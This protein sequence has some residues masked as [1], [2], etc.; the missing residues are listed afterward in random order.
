MEFG[1]LGPLEVRSQGR[2]VALPGVKQRALLAILLLNANEVVA[3]DRLIDALSPESGINALQALVSRLRKALAEGGQ[4]LETKPAGYLL[5]LEPGQRDLDSFEQLTAEAAMADPETAAVK[6]REALALWRGPALAEFAYADFAQS[7][8]GRLEEMRLTALERRI[9]ADLQVGRHADVVGELEQLTTQH[10]LRERLRGQL[11]LA[12]YRCGRQ[13][14]ALE[15]YQA[16]RRSL[17]E[18]LGIDPGSALRELEQAILRQDPDLE[19][20]APTGKRHPAG[21][22][23]PTNL[24]TPATPLVGRERELEALTELIGRDE[25]RLVTLTGPGGVG[26]TRLALELARSL[27]PDYPDGVY[28]L[29]LASLREPA[30]LLSTLAQAL[31]VR[32]QPKRTVLETLTDE[33]KERQLLLFLDNLEHLLEVAPDLA[34]L[35]A[36]CPKLLLLVT[37][38]QPL[39]LAGEH[40]YALAPLR[41]EEAFALFL[42]RAR[43]LEPDFS[44][45]GEVT[46]ICRR[47]DCLPLAL[48]LAAARVKAL[49]AS[50]ILERLGERLPLLTGGPRDLPE[51]QQTLRAT[52]A[53]SYDLLEEDEQRLF[54]R[55]SVFAGGCTLEA[56]EEVCETELNTLASLLDKSLLRRRGERYSMLETIREYAAERLKQA[57]EGEETKARHADYVLVLTREA[58]EELRGAEQQLWLDRLEEEQDNIRVALGWLEQTGQTEAQLDL[59]RTMSYFWDMRGRWLEGLRWLEPAL[60]RSEGER[61]ARRAQALYAAASLLW[62]Y[63][64]LPGAQAYAEESLSVS[65][66][67]GDSVEIA[68]ALIVLAIIAKRRGNFRQAERLHEAAAAHARKAGDRRLLGYTTGN[69]ATL[70]LRE[71]DYGRA[72]SLSKET[73]ALYR[74]LGAPD[75][76]GWSLLNLALSLLLA[77]GEEQ[78][79]PPARES[80]ALL[81]RVGDLR[82][83]LYTFIVFASL[84]TRRGE[85]GA[86]ARLLGAVEA[87]RERLSLAL[88]G[89]EEEL[90]ERT[91][92][93]LR[94]VLGDDVFEAH[95]AEGRSLSLDEAVAYALEVVPET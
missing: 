43:A 90:R 95:F 47:L 91:A 74:Q 79:I 21:E 76:I 72:A 11:M 53:W 42:E 44:A 2:L 93:D 73:L 29:A 50:Q 1:I 59:A 77:G 56:A 20:P 48:E 66:E 51:R 26:K 37:S 94:R 6:L 54:R 17:V 84:A 83:I 28:G 68:R 16:A 67:L 19:H 31:G 15:V 18:E 4:L 3:S 25:V 27:L 14:E 63:G 40:E 8:L 80:L 9:D 5:Q 10:P 58:R 36:S 55:L 12:L 23:P 70:A 52:I 60:A 81:H 92:G 85:T 49:S 7:A 32:E 71:G 24:P 88:T 34:R 13:A 46:E 33:L 22:Q 39:H 75:T 35:L 87:L 69:L 78:A 38:R 62:P 41:E 86:G 65:R 89:R 45:N 64:D 82:G 30:L 61:S 57:A